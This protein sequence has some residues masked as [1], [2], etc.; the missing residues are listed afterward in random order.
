MIR[1]LRLLSGIGLIAGASLLAIPE[2]A[3]AWSTI[4][5][6]LSLT[7]R[8]FR[9]YNNFPGTNANNNTAQT[10][11]FPGY[12][13]AELSI[14]KGGAEWNSRAHGDGS[15]DPLQSTLGNGGANFSFFWNGNAS[16]PGT[17]ND[18]IVASL[19]GSSGG[20]LAYM[21]GP[22][23]N[24]WTI[25]FYGSAWNWHDGPSSIGSGMDIQ[26]VAC[27]ELGHALGLGHSNSS[28]STMYAYASSNGTPDRSIEADDIA[29]IKAVYGS[30]NT[31]SMPK[32]DDITGTFAPGG[33]IN[34]TGENFT[35]T[36]NRL[37]LNRSVLDQ[38]Y[39]GGE[40]LKVS[41][42]SSTQGG[43]NMSVTLPA[44]GWETGGEIHV[45][46]SANSNY[47]LS[48]SHPAES[49]GLAIDTIS[50]NLSTQIPQA[51]AYITVTIADP[52]HPAAPFIVHWSN[53]LAGTVINNQ[54][55]QI[56]QPQGVAGFGNLNILGNKTF[57]KRV[58]PAASGRT[59]YVEVQ[60]D[61]G[62]LTFDSN[63]ITVWIQ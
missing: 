51:G 16:G 63:V 48:E 13:G 47:A 27:H 34:I 19:S 4:G 1:G 39:T 21:Q 3:L 55:F 14:W 62:G 44:S 33:T 50:L 43:T 20:V 25:K 41:N 32:I 7:Q 12:D 49:S 15:G 53:T 8:D 10:A 9:L 37:W 23:S 28:S 52:P 56:G 5:G 30:M 6:S 22:I 40:P 54:P 31:S 2:Q 58:P 11:N 61:Y 36:G 42:L 59:V 57:S 18:N 35:A 24:G 45:Q 29:G 26:G 60:V 46:S 17:S 38:G